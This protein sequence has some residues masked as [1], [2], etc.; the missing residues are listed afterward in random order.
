M[1]GELG[2]DYFEGRSWHG[3]LALERQREER[4]PAKPG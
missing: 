3:F 1:K 2:L 4:A